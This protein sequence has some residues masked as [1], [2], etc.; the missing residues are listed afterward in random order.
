MN[1]Q[2]FEGD[3]GCLEEEEFERTGWYPSLGHEITGG[4]D[5]CREE[6]GDVELG[7]S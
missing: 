4:V 7:V 1:D 6:E 2:V 3:G 5:K